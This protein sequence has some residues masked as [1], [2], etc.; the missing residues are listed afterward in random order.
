MINSKDF[1]FGFGGTTGDVVFYK[2]S[3]LKDKSS[4]EL[5]NKLK[6]ADEETEIPDS[7]MEISE[8]QSEEI[9]GLLQNLGWEVLGWEGPVISFEPPSGTDMKSI[10]ETL[11]FEYSEAASAWCIYLQ[12]IDAF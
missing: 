1:V 11:G 12:S 7:P 5:V 8:E 9:Q 2:K 10:I 4:A 3:A 6:E